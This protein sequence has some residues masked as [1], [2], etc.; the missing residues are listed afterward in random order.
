MV[1]PSHYT[2]AHLQQRKNMKPNFRSTKRGCD[3]VAISACGHSALSSK[4]HSGS[5]RTLIQSLFPCCLHNGFTPT[6]GKWG[7]RNFRRFSRLLVHSAPEN[8]NSGKE[9]SF[10]QCPE[11]ICSSQEFRAVQTMAT[12]I[13]QPFMQYIRDGAS[14]HG[15]LMVRLDDLRDIFQP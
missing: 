1:M 11:D 7:R 6:P 8:I 5:Q 15:G 14:G 9:K 2:C 13:S 12:L 10:I 3:C 4:T